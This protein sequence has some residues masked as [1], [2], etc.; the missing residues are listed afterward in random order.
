MWKSII[1]PWPGPALREGWVRVRSMEGGGLEQLQPKP[2]ERSQGSFTSRPPSQPTGSQIGQWSSPCQGWAPRAKTVEGRQQ[3]GGRNAKNDTKGN[4][5]P[6]HV[7]SEMSL[8]S[9]RCYSR[10]VL[11]SQYLPFPPSPHPKLDSQPTFPPT[12]PGRPGK[13]ID[14]I[15]CFHSCAPHVCSI[16]SLFLHCSLLGGRVRI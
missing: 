8:R 5:Q 10:N 12:A 7:A 16:S 2:G 15:E 6:Y 14:V 3:R 1:S 11:R 9:R 4:S 13:E